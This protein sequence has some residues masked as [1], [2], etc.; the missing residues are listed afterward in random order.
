[1]TF[2]HLIYLGSQKIQNLIPKP[3]EFSFKDYILSFLC[4]GSI[5]GKISLLS[6]GE[7]LIKKKL[8]IEN[9]ILKL[10]EI[11][12]LKS[13]LFDPD[14]LY[15]F[16][17]LPK[18]VLKSTDKPQVQQ[19]STEVKKEEKKAKKPFQNL[20]DSLQAEIQFSIAKRT[21]SRIFAW[22]KGSQDI[23]L[24]HLNQTF[25]SVF[26]K[27]KKSPI[28]EKFIDVYKKYLSQ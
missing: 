24:D 3:I 25:W 22:K 16:N 5:Q 6:Q 4:K 1:M 9:I 19:K 27:D 13:Y 8:D 11:D 23:D 26:Y 21:I 10:E 28:D 15:L 14:Q 18:P 17:N 2:S 7:E 12:K 20:K